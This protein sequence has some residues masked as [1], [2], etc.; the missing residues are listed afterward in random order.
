MIEKFER[1]NNGEIVQMAMIVGF[2]PHDI[3]AVREVKVKGEPKKVLSSSSGNP[4]S[5]GWKDGGR[6]K[7]EFMSLEFWGNSAEVMKKYGYKGMPISVSGRIKKSSYKRCDEVVP[8][9][10]LIVDKFEILRFRKKEDG[11]SG[12][13]SEV[14]QMQNGTEGKQIQVN[15]DDMPF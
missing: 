9:E 5:I 15:P 6:D 12:E 11:G 13:M 2:L 14:T 1:I 8:Y 3:P 7:K 4:F 10:T